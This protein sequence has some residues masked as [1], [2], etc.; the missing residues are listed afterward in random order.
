MVNSS[1][2]D[3]LYIISLLDI[4]FHASIEVVDIQSC[5]C[6][7]ECVSFHSNGSFLVLSYFI[8]PVLVDFQVKFVSMVIYFLWIY[9]WSV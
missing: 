6:V 8:D 9:L 4:R 3:Q 2:M 1:E 7:D 5:C